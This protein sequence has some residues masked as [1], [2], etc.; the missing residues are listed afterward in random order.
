MY[1]I[2][3]FALSLPVFILS[4]QA[5]AD[6]SVAK[7]T[8][9]FYECALQSHPQYKAAVVSSG[10]ADAYE[11]KAK[12]LPN[13]EVT[14]SSNKGRNLGESTGSSEIT[15]TLN[16]TELLVKRGAYI[17]IGNAEKRLAKVE[18]EELTFSA[19]QQLIRDLYRYRQVLEEYE[20][21]TEA[22]GA[23]RKIEGQ[24]ASRKARSPEQDV[25]LSLVQL[26]QGDYELR[27]NHLA[28]EKDEII[29]RFKGFLGPQFDLKKEV[30][31]AQRTSWPEIKSGAALRDTFELRR[32]TAK[33]DRLD[34]E[35][36][37]VVADSWPKI[38]AGPS[39][40]RV[41]EG[42]NSYNTT[43]FVMTIDLP[44]LTWNSGGREIA[45]RTL[46]V[47]R[48]EQQYSANQESLRKERLVQLYNGAVD[49]LKR[50]VARDSVKRKHNQ[51]DSLFR[52]GFTSGATVIEAHR[53]ITEYTE[54]QHEHE[55]LALDS[56]MQIK[57]LL[58]EEISGVLK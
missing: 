41:T 39:F 32:V 56:L 15:A 38:S 20:L 18:S 44:V 46:E 12:Q 31:P 13:P 24:F 17:K 49:A 40:E 22:L 14:V 9:D 25:S 23:F 4:K 2:R 7:N 48:L 55:L 16:L 57:L 47:A 5:F 1:L 30:L 29:S 53:Q 35:R 37:Q 26:A 54:S 3:I 36:S 58:G 27:R 21:V 52:S 8:Y 6:C 28:V 51:I 19:K 34:A 43:G 45:N 33:R 42:T 11:D 10:L 50:S